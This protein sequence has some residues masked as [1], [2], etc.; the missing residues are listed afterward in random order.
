MESS[1]K[2]V[3]LSKRA[4]D[5]AA[6]TFKAAADTSHINHMS[7]YLVLATT[8]FIIALQYFTSD[9]PLFPFERNIRTFIYSILILIPLL[10]VCALALYGFDKY[11]WEL[12]WKL[13]AALGRKR[14]K[15]QKNLSGKT[16]K[17]N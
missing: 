1:F 7:V 4:T 8:P 10:F 15:P 2:A 17:Q 6:V 9:K 11:K 3:K 12:I 5:I 14:R 16:A 13:Y